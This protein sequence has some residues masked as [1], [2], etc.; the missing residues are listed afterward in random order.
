MASTV[1]V[2]AKLWP[3][4]LASLTI[5]IGVRYDWLLALGCLWFGASLA[6]LVWALKSFRTDAAARFPESG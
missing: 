4:W 2:L 3:L 1:K 6:A 5:I